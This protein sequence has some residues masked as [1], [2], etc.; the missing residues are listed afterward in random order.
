MINSWGAYKEWISD[1][2]RNN[3]TYFYRG[4]QNPNWKLETTFQRYA[5]NNGINW[6]Q[7]FNQILPEVN[8]Q[9]ASFGYQINNFSDHT[10]VG[11]FLAKLQ[12]HGFPT[13]LLDWTTSPYVA[14]Y[15]ALKDVNSRVHINGNEYVK[16]YMFDYQLWRM[17]YMQIQFLN[18][19]APFLSEFR[20]SML[21]NQRLVS[22]MAVTTVTN[23]PDVELYL[24]QIQRAT[25]KVFLYY[26]LLPVKDRR[27][28][29]SELNLMGINSSTMFPSFDG[30]CMSLKEQFFNNIDPIVNQNNL[31]VPPPPSISGV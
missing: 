30:M 17:N 13:P 20:P 14:A 15:F 25:G 10:Q 22:Q 29:M 12:H 8:Y 5:V 27:V 19:T 4:Q 26:A 3:H 23:V 21:D 6:H 31:P 11:G 16:I 7:Y 24:N 9:S 28:I 2:I 1:L 18:A